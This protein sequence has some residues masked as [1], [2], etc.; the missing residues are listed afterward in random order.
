MPPHNSKKSFSVTIA[1]VYRRADLGCKFFLQQQKYLKQ[2]PPSLGPVLLQSYFD[3][4]VTKWDDDPRWIIECDWEHGDHMLTS[5]LFA[6]ESKSI[7]TFG[8]YMGW[9]L[10]SFP[11][12]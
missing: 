4:V 11:V 2:I 8:P 7:H 6:L 10:P 9:G 3:I 12:T 1:E 5:M